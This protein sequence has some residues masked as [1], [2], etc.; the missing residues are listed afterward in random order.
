MLIYIAYKNLTNC[1]HDGASSSVKLS[2]SRTVLLAKEETLDT[3]SL[4]Y[5]QYHHNHNDHH[6]HDHDN[7]HTHK[8]F[9]HTFCLQ[10]KTHLIHLHG[11]YHLRMLEKD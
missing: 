7:H 11:V 4:N 9:L 5:H 1:V 6:G 8:T 3:L 10:R 2:A